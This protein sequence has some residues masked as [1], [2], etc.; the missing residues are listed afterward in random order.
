[1]SCHLWSIFSLSLYR[2]LMID[3][4]HSGSFYAFQHPIQSNMRIQYS[5]DHSHIVWQ[6]LTTS[7]QHPQDH[8]S[9]PMQI[10]TSLVVVGLLRE[11]HPYFKPKMSISL[12]PSCCPCH[13]HPWK[14]I[15][16][17][18]LAHLRTWEIDHIPSTI[19]FCLEINNEHCYVPWIN[20]LNKHV[21]LPTIGENT[22]IDL[23]FFS[24]HQ[25][26]C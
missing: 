20:S 5:Q 26:S 9:N 13:W 17:F 10:S 15:S 24:W 8:F 22:F 4:F 14:E 2:H 16:W 19:M 25:R 1:M 7:I 6:G 18:P 12:K 23:Q 21:F 11:T 3:H